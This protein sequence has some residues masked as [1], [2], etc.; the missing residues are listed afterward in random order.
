MPRHEAVNGYTA[1]CDNAETTRFRAI[2]LRQQSTEVIHYF[3]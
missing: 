3:L 2:S 1:F